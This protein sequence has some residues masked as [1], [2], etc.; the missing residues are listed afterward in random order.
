MDHKSWVSMQFPEQY[1]Y[2]VTVVENHFT[3]PDHMRLCKHVMC[4][5]Y[6]KAFT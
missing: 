1:L 4:F 5:G 2:L 6:H 3:G